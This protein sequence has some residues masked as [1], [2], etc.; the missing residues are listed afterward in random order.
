MVYAGNRGP[1]SGRKHSARLRVA[2]A[3]E[4]ADKAAAGERARP[5]ISR[6]AEPT[7]PE[8]CQGS[9]GGS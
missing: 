4:Q 8:R 1:A 3:G 2:S 9:T 5:R 7:S 6:G